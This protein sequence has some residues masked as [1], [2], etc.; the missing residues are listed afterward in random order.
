MFLGLGRYSAE[1]RLVKG[2]RRRPLDPADLAQVHGLLAQQ[3]RSTLPYGLLWKMH[4]LAE[5]AISG[6]PEDDPCY[7]LLQ[8]IRHGALWEIQYR[9]LRGV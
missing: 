8:D 4:V 1:R 3:S 2:L 7:V 9:E 6:M 5:K